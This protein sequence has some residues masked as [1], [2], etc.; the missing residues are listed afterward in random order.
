MFWFNYR[1][2][3]H[4][5]P[6]HLLTKG[7]LIIILQKLLTNLHV[8]ALRDLEFCICS[9]F[10]FES[11]CRHINGL[12][13]QLSQKQLKVDLRSFDLLKG[14]I[15]TCPSGIPPDVKGLGLGLGLGLCSGCTNLISLF[16]QLFTVCEKLDDVCLQLIIT[17]VIIVMIIIVT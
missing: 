11:E 5:F 2:Q 15:S 9:V 7:A 17:I 14:Q 1:I 16:N 4:S 10:L 6:Y 3:G 8:L 12:G 13:R